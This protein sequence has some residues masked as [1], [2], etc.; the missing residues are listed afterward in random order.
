MEIYVNISFITDLI[1]SYGH[2]VV[3]IDGKFS[4]NGSL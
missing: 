1:Y 2:F 3:R 4:L